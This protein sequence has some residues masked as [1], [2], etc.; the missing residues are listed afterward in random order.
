MMQ[1]SAETLMVRIAK[2]RGCSLPQT[3]SM[4]EESTAKVKSKVHD[5]CLSDMLVL[6][7]HWSGQTVEIRKNLSCE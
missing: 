2:G 7:T 6:R 5:S 1:V 4:V 3:T